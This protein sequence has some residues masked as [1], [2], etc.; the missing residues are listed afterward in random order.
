MQGCHFSD[1]PVL[2]SSMQ[3]FHLKDD[4]H[5]TQ[6]TAVSCSSLGSRLA[7]YTESG[8]LSGIRLLSL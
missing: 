8:K 4:T 5:D 2:Q 6:A 3:R 1:R 7:F